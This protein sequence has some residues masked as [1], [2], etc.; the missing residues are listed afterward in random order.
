VSPSRLDWENARAR[1]RAAGER[2]DPAIPMWARLPPTAKQLRYI[3]ILAKGNRVEVDLPA[4]RGEAAQVI[5]H[6]RAERG[7][8]P[9]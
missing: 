2:P 1:Q 8:P 5:A 7:L 3:A 4:T 6:L 9:R